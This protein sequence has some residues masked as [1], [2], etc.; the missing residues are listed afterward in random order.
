[1]EQDEAGR[2]FV[3]AK[4]G[5]DIQ[6][7][8][9]DD[10]PINLTVAL[11]FLARH[12]IKA[13]TAGGGE[14]A[15][16]MIAERGAVNGL[17]KRYDMVFMDH[18]MPEVDGIEASRR[19]RALAGGSAENAWYKDMPI[20]ALTA[21]AVSGVRELFLEAGMNDFI[22]KPIEAPALNTVL[23]KGR[24]AEKLLNSFS[25]EKPA[26]AKTDAGVNES[27]LPAAEDDPLWAELNAIP[28]LNTEDGVSYT[29]GTREGYYRVLRQ[30]CS[31][32]DEGMRVITGDVE[33]EDWND[34]TV[35]T[36]AYKGVLAMIGH[37]TLSDWARQLEAAGKSAAHREGETDGVAA[38]SAIALIKG[39]TGPICE[40]LR[41]FRDAL[42]A[43]TLTL[44]ESSDSKTK[45]SSSELTEKLKALQAACAAFKMG[46]AGKITAFLE[47]VSVD[48]EADAALAEIR[49]LAESLDY[50]EAVE[51]IA[52]FLEKPD[53]GNL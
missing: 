23:S 28:G 47:Q 6:I 51:K 31:G 16:R 19:I 9:V 43:T 39:A 22:S 14:E 3:R 20:V 38:A 36:H 44:K 8:V 45:I 13:D 4:E 41:N 33:N 34:Y 42:L 32:F 17:K 40:A 24:P 12:G 30:F 48:G 18:M 1:V 52:A 7:L 49:R 50:E 15:V 53:R 35:R 25:V 11:G 26:G 46:E 2:Q 10:M 5:A 37:K 21:N 29:G 27:A